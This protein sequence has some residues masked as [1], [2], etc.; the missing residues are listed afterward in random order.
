MS[1]SVKESLRDNEKEKRRR[2]E[3]MANLNKRE[4][5]RERS[6]ITAKKTSSRPEIL[7]ARTDQLAKWRNENPEAFREKCTDKM[8]NSWQ[9]IPEKKLFNIVE[10]R[11]EGFKRNQRVYDSRFETKS[12]KRQI[13]IFCKDRKIIIEFDGPLH[14]NDYFGKDNLATT[15]RKDKRLNQIMVDK[16]YCVIRVSHDTYYPKEEFDQSIIN[17]LFQIISE[18]KNELYLL[19]NSYES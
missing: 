6:S 4:D 2:S 18:A 7:K 12:K 1:V 9:S 3:L 14:F 11:F 8:L 10:E 13:D 19:G 17:N 16:G 5:F 15:Q